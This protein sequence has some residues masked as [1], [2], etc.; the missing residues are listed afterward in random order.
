MLHAS[1]WN[2]ALHRY[3]KPRISVKLAASMSAFK[4][5]SKYTLQNARELGQIYLYT[6]LMAGMLALSLTCMWALL[7]LVNAAFSTDNG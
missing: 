2:S 6:Y 7:C 1:A 3:S 4:Y 5:V